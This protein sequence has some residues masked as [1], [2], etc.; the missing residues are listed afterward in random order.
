MLGPSDLYKLV[1]EI[2]KFIQNIRSLGTDLSTTFESNMQNQL[3]LEELRKAQ[4]E[5]T[6]A[7][8]FRRSINVDD[9]EAFATT[10]TS[11]RAEEAASVGAAAVDGAGNKKKK[12]IRVK[13]RKPVQESPEMAPPPEPIGLPS[14]R[15]E[16]S[17]PDLTMPSSTGDPFV[18]DTPTELTKEEEEEIEREFEKYT[19]LGDPVSSSWT[20][21]NEKPTNSVQKAALTKEEEAAASLRF[22][23]QSSNEWNKKIMENEDKLSPLAK[24]MEMLAVLEKE[25]V[26]KTQLLEEEFR[27]RAE[28]DEEYYKKQRKILEDAAIQ[29]QKDAQKI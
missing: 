17:V 7:F 5:L 19:S 27:K 1:K 13:K 29:V 10:T 8:S 3:Q 21:D 16:T 22:Q 24:V 28:M 26:S 4:Q 12:R 25:K 14:G 18:D 9:S 11:P 20:N 15:I 2:G 6:D 23:Q